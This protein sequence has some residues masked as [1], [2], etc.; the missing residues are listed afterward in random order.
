MQNWGE[1]L[2]NQTTEKKEGKK[3]R[4]KRRKKRTPIFLSRD[5]YGCPV[6]SFLWVTE[7]SV[8]SILKDHLS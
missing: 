5:I 2:I 4:K 8:M 3:G 7:T 6:F 1:V